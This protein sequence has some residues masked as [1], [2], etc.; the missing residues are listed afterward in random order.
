MDNLT[1][2]EHWERVKGIVG[3]ALDCEP[4]RRIAFLDE[5]CGSNATLRAE[6]E[7]LVAAY[8]KASGLFQDTFPAVSLETAAPSDMI[9]DYRLIKKLGEGG[10]GQVWLAEQTAPVERQVALKLVRA[11][12]YDE[13]LLRRFQ[14]E[15]QS[16]AIMD[17]PVIAKVFDAGTTESGQPYFVMEY[18]Q[19]TPINTYCDQH[20]LK[21]RDRLELFIKVCDGVQHAHQKAIIHRDLKPANILVVEVDGEP[22]P[23]IIDFGLAKAVTPLSAGETA[24]TQIGSF[25][26][27]PAY[28][29]PEQADPDFHDIDTR[30]DV[31]SLGVVLYELLTGSTPFDPKQWQK[32][33]LLEVLRQL[34]E[35][36]PLRP[37]TRVKTEK[38]SSAAAKRAVTPER[39]T[40]Q[41]RGDLDTIVGKALKKNPQ[42]RYASVTAFA[43]D[44]RRYL[45]NKPITAR[46]D[47]IAYRAAKFVRR[48][49]IA[50]ALT[51]LA[52]VAAIAGVTGTLMQA[53]TARRQ[54]DFAFRELARA[55]KIDS[56]NE[57]LLSD[58]QSGKA[59]T[60]NE[61]LEREELIIERENRANDA[62][63]HVKMLT[64][65]GTQ[66]SN[67]GEYDKALRILKEA[68]QLSLGLQEP[69]VRAR[70]A[71]ALAIPL[72]HTSAQAR[73]EAAIAEGLRGLPQDPEFSFDRVF[74]LLR[75][76]E[77][78]GYV[79][80][81]GAE[82]AL[83]RAQN[84]IR[85]LDDS[86]FHPDN[87]KF[88][89]S[90]SLADAYVLLGRFHEAIAAYEQAW[91]QMTRLG[92]DETASAASLLHDWALAVILAGR[93][94]EAEKIYHRAIEINRGEQSNVGLLNDYAGALRELGRFDEALTYAKLAYIK[95]NEAKDEP[96]IES[97]LVQLVR[98][99]REQGDLAQ[100]KLKIAELEPIRARVY[101][102]GHYAFAS[103]V[104]ERSLI[105]QGEGDIPTALRLANRAVSMDESA[106]KAG[107]QGAHLM[108][109]LLLRRSGIELD[110]GEAD[111]AAA[112]A[113]R[114]LGLAQASVEL[115]DY[116]EHVGRAYL[117][118]GRALQMQGKNDQAQAAFLSATK[119][120]E[121]AVGPDHPDTRT[122]RRL[123]GL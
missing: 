49:R 44:L 40:R 38:D 90:H 26:G 34:R 46:P 2:R 73:A 25:V 51:A 64:S 57:F 39:L 121:N 89:A 70:A 81:G 28:M 59:L 43:N 13:S 109:T 74:C 94:L 91:N 58:A 106:I 62:A 104:S 42:E 4:A 69:S 23:R 53:R 48:N 86:P 27:T 61:L 77:V 16:L 115:G 30:T 68:Y 67:K 60:V 79:E 19:G 103:L 97:T 84:A 10:M 14:A 123:A 47:K 102:P 83:V 113:T 88:S 55:E 105:A 5:V 117:A 96:I 92:Y 50:V 41:L 6:V 112:D 108:P 56:L 8:E 15:R 3:D 95:A 54:R 122:A 114:A 118:L 107:G 17:H 87:L 20:Q 9:G 24:F 75:G 35:Q 93:P 7:T 111:E 12:L 76:S 85:I 31:Y 116:S 37:S 52:L 36:D 63:S 22:M 120:L 82:I 101:P 21:I 1:K 32:Q 72:F 66:Y 33:P 99:Y 98:T 78:A 110:A 45:R 71:C 80:A 29:S 18:V 119:H 65:L 100:A 11:G